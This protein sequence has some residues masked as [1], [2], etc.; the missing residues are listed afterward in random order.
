MFSINVNNKSSGT[1]ITSTGEKVP[2]G[3]GWGIGSGGDP[4]WVDTP[5]GR[6]GIVDIGDTHVPG[7][8]TETWGVLVGYQEMSVVGRYE[9]KGMLI[10]D[11]NPLYQVT[12]S[13][14]MDFRQV[15]L[16]GLI[17]GAVPAAA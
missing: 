13:G 6:L 8:S 7:D 11:V 16:D 9:G 12:M 2:P 10:L 17:I 1:L 5:M 4:I 14:G 15:S 3:S